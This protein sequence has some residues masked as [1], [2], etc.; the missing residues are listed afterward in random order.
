MSVHTSP[1]DGSHGCASCPHQPVHLPLPYESASFSFS[2]HSARWE[3]EKRRQ[4]AFLL[5]EAKIISPG[6]KPYLTALLKP[7]FY[8]LHQAQGGQE[9]D[10][11]K[12]SLH[13][14]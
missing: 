2:I 5:E 9:A 10:S 1:S 7:L 3:G 8:P 13:P 4:E 12:N 11:R 6:Q 14:C